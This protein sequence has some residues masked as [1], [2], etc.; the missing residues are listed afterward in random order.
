MKIVI[1]DADTMGKDID[2]SPIKAI[3]E[4]VIFPLTAPNE[5]ADRI[6]DADVV[7]T[8][9]VLLGEKELSSAKNLKLICLFAI[10][11]NN[12]D[13]NYCKEHNILVRNVPGYCVESVCQHT[14][15]LLFMLIENLRYY[16]DF[17]KSFSYSSQSTANHI[18][19]PF[20]EIAG[21]KWGI[22]GMGAIG[23]SVAKVASAFGAKVTY[24]S[25]SGAVRKED[26]DEVPLKTLLSESDIITIHAPLN[27]KTFHLIGKKEFEMMKDTAV[28]VNVGRGAIIDEEALSYALDNDLIGGA[29]IDVFTNEPP[30]ASS[31]LMTVK[32][33]EKLVFSPHMAWASSQARE[34]CIK[35]TADNIKAFM[36]NERLHDVW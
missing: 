23:R 27:E 28:L 1:L 7:V 21:L 4:T 30:E 5:I 18:G 16:D 32:K 11:F 9:K 3:G 29:A 15:A 8:N 14:F 31:P 19:R 25:I 35:M 13:I 6:K 34:R 20:R 12:I 2:F 22:I 26:Y 36:N 17:V 33:K 10:G 24:S